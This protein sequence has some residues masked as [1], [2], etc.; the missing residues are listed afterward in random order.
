MSYDAFL[1][2]ETNK[3]LSSI[4]DSDE[5]D[6][7]LE[8][9][10]TLLDELNGDKVYLDEDCN[11]IFK[12]DNDVSWIED[13]EDSDWDYTTSSLDEE[14]LIELIIKMNGVNNESSNN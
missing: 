11:E 4:D 9:K 2:R 10:Y 14:E 7:Y 13:G 6:Q 8:E 12:V 3:Y 1:N 5:F